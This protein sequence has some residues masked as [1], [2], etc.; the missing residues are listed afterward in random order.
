[1][2]SRARLLILVFAL[3]GLA[4]AGS[5]AWVHYKLITQPAYV[6][7]CDINATFSC[8]Q[9][10]MSQ[11][12]AIRGVPV[13]VG[14][15]IWFALVGLLAAFAR[16]GERNDPTGAYVF[17][18]AT[19]GLGAVIYLA[20]ASFVVLKMGCVLCIG[21]Y[22][23]VVGI[24]L[25]SSASVS[26]PMTRL[27]G[28]LFNDLRTLVSRPTAMLVA[29]LFLG[30][31]AS[32]IAFFP[33]EGGVSSSTST[34]AAGAASATGAAGA[35]GAAAS[36]APA[37]GTQSADIDKAFADAWFQQH[38]VDIGVPANGAKVLIV[39]FI[40][41]QCPSC[42]AAHFA[43]KPI[44]D[45][46]E[47][48]NPGAV[49]QVIKD[50]PLNSR[51]NYGVSREMHPSACEE[52]AAVRIAREKG[53]EAELVTWLFGMPDVPQ[54]QRTPDMVEAQLKQLIGVQDFAREYAS[55][56]PDIKRDVAD[57][58]A[59]KVSQTPTYFINGVRAQTEQGW[60][61]PHYF[62]LAIKLELD[63]AS[64]KSPQP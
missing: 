24:F 32:A 44:L 14:G 39:K 57:G 18:L 61:P 62:G 40:D 55:R 63:K 33:K 28:R 1:M 8:S 48:T 51:C 11:Y 53:K 64:G 3:A 7:P 25:V 54:M 2:T 5:S 21:T 17:A 23:S 36:A 27:P 38:R 20:Y 47:K 37:I 49:R 26:M 34:A 56:L 30:F 29:I 60:L 59:L 19:V 12:G 16:P 50:Y 15:L 52:A 31:A 42:K 58:G 6:S 10:Y 35:A 4:F 41:W 46:F 13:A 22:V 43:Y 45:E 9:V